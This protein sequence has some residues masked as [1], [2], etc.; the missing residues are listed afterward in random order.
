LEEL[1]AAATHAV[2]GLDRVVKRRIRRLRKRGVDDW[3]PAF[4]VPV[5][6]PAAWRE[7]VDPL[8]AAVTDIV[9]AAR[10]AMELERRFRDSATS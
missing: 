5:A 9:T 6:T 3:S 2:E 1:L 4:E 7:A 10:V 8:Q